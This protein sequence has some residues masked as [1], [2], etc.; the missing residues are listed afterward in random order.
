M[1]HCMVPGCT[2][3]SRKTTGITYHR[4]PKDERLRQAWMA[5]IRRANPRNLENSC[6]CAEHFTPD[7]F[8]E[9]G[10][11]SRARLRPNSVPSIFPRSEPTTPRTTGRMRTQMR[12]EQAKRQVK[13]WSLKYFSI[14]CTIERVISLT[15]KTYTNTQI[16]TNID[17]F[18]LGSIHVQNSVHENCMFS[19][20]RHKIIHT[21]ENNIF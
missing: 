10:Y 20:I 1:P 8:E 12:S 7:C 18:T 9:H 21:W 14:K 15:V 13:R 2:N 3:S 11:Q 19:S 16:Y 6:V 17:K 5:R 4:V